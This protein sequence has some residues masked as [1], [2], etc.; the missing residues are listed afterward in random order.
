MY[1]MTIFAL[2]F[3]LLLHLQLTLATAPIPHAEPARR[4]LESLATF[5]YA[6]DNFVAEHPQFIGNLYWSSGDAHESLV[7]AVTT[8]PGL[9]GITLPE[10]WWAKVGTAGYTLC[11]HV[12][13]TLLPLIS[14][15][16]PERL[17]P[18]Q[19]TLE[20]SMDVWVFAAAE[21]TDQELQQCQH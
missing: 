6:V 21:H 1:V 8:P 12:D 4:M 2:F 15:R 7:D 5:A 20:N 9:R 14:A 13:A 11:V 17:Q 16:M 3:G 18:Q 10:D 19:R